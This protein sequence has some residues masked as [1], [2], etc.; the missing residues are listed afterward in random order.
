MAWYERQRLEPPAALCA[1]ADSDDQRAAHGCCSKRV[2][3][4]RNGSG[5][6]EVMLIQALRCQGSANFWLTVGAVVPPPES[7]TV[8]P[9]FAP[10]EWIRAMPT[11]YTTVLVAPPD[12]PP[13]LSLA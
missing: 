3:Q 6:S 7:V 9:D 4:Q 11:S 2:Q 5:A 12:P 13:K 8:A 10:R 1:T